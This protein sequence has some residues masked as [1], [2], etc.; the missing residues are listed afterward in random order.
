MAS[1]S[2]Y[3]R[4][5]PGSE[6]NVTRQEQ[7]ENQEFLLEARSI[8][9]EGQIVCPRCE[10]HGTESPILVDEYDGVCRMCNGHR[11]IKRRVKVIVEDLP[12]GGEE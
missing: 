3:R 11:V 4:E 8:L 12:V 6:D 5:R 2:R 9:A 7:I 10:G 1:H